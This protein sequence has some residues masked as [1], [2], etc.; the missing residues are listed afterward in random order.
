MEVKF[1]VDIKIDKREGGAE[2]VCS[3]EGSEPSIVATILAVAALCDSANL[4]ELDR[5]VAAAVI[6]SGLADDDHFL[7]QTRD[8][9]KSISGG[10]SDG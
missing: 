8:A 6:M 1:T 7:P 9:I 3:S 10:I 5:R 2:T 4:S